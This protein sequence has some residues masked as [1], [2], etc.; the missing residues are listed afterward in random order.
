MANVDFPR[1]AIPYRGNMNVNYYDIGATAIYLYDLVERRNDGLVYPAQASSIT[2]IGSAAEYKAA[3][4]TG[5]I[6]VYDD[7]NMRF[8]MQ[9]SDSDIDVQTDLDLV[10]NIVA[11]TGNTTTKQSKHEID[12][13]TGAATA[14][15][16]IKILR[17]A[18]VITKA[19]NALGAN[20]LCEVIINNHLLKSTGVIG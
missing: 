7:P 6:A 13:T 9:A 8:L 4:S 20:V 16:P 1:G 10:Y 5:R 11:T 17:I 12:S 15:L 18:D 3:S 19:G 14:T 2:I